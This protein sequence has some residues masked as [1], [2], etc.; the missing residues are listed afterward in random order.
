V[1]FCFLFS[2]KTSSQGRCFGAIKNQ[3]AILRA[4]A[5]VWG[6]GITKKRKTLFQRSVAE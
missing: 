4:A 3:K 5:S 6:R 1:A 2:H